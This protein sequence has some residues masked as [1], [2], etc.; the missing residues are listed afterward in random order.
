MAT[1][2]STYGTI[3]KREIS[4]WTIRRVAISAVVMTLWPWRRYWRLLTKSSKECCTFL[5]N[6]W[7]IYCISF[8]MWSKKNFTLSTIGPQIMCNSIPE[9]KF[10]GQWYIWCFFL[11][12]DEGSSTLS[13]TLW[14]SM[15]SSQIICRMMIG[16]LTRETQSNDFR[17]DQCFGFCFIKSL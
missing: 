4:Y 1:F 3:V 11:P 6:R 9:I 2:A 13:P 5:R 16:P 10:K 7:L 12:Y 8:C 14:V 15:V 17:K